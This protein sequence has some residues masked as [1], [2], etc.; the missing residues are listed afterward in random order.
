MSEKDSIERAIGTV[1]DDGELAGAVS[2]V[3]RNGDVV[4][5]AAVGWRNMEAGL[6]M[7]RDTL[8]R[9]ASMSKPIT[10]LAALILMEEGR[11]ALDDPIVRWAPEFTEM[12]V[13]RSPA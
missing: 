9:I 7:E 3:W 11:F 12:R 13:L 6:P 10:S 1:V 8:F 5:S 4:Q 2:L